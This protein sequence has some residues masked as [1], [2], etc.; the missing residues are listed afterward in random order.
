MM[1]QKLKA[2][3]PILDDIVARLVH[4]YHP[5]RIY[6]FGSRATGTY[7]I[8]SDYDI[9]LVVNNGASDELKTATP[10]YKCLWGIRAAV[11]VVVWTEHEFEIRLP[12][13]NSLPA[14]VVREG[15]LLHVA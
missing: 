3:D 15:L 8:D 11:D 14:A 2:S 6:L 4:T 5:L 7:R 1:A 13:E 10:A 12:V 9:L